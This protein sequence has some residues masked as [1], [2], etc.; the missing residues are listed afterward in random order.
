M[1]ALRVLLAIG[2]SLSWGCGGS[3]MTA[4]P[5]GP[6]GFDLDAT[7]P[8]LTFDSVRLRDFYEPSA[9]ASRLLLLRVGAAWCGT[10]RWHL[11]HTGELLASDIGPS[12]TIVD[13]V[14]ADE[15]NV[16]AT[17]AAV[18]A[19]RARIDAPTTVASDPA[20]QLQPAMFVAG[21]L[22]LIVAVDRRTMTIQAT[23]S[24]PD[25][26]RLDAEL[27]RAL[28]R[29]NKTALA[30]GPST[31]GPDGLHRNQWD[32]V[33]E[34]ALP[35]A[36]PPDPTNA[37]ADDPAAAA[38][39]RALYNDASLSPSGTVSCAT[40]HDPAKGF[41]DGR[42]QSV[43]VATGDRNAPSVLFASH[44]RWQ[45]WDGRAD[46]LWAQALGPFENPKEFDSSRLFVAHAI[47]DRYRAQYEAI[48]GALPPLSDGARF[49]ASGKPGSIEWMNMTAAD[50]QAVNRVYANVGK[51][52][53]AF[54][55]TLR[56]RPNA[57]DRY[58][59]GDA[60]ALTEEQKESLRAFFEGGCAQCHYGP[61]LT[62]DAF[63]AIR[64]PTGRPDGVGDPGR[65]EG[66]AKLRA[67]E[68]LGRGAYSDAPAA[69]RDFSALAPTANMRGAFK[70]PPLRGIAD[71]A[72][73]GHGGTIATL[74]DVA[75]LYGK[76]GLPPEDRAAVGA[77]EPW[78]P[79]FLD[80]DA[81]KLVPFLQLLTAEPEPAP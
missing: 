4:Y 81:A 6:Y 19:Y 66:I 78:L 57:L 33:R 69:A 15:D 8:D 47:F 50:Q 40:C 36:P 62:D 65:E 5:P 52:I 32:L 1:R 37:K 77:S 29:L 44:A 22:P 3:S 10:C 27:K 55:R 26:D 41:A 34:M 79:L 28:N 23:L 18:P 7:L 16:P 53:A 11:A 56:A 67:S 71:T 14:V 13:L 49:P 43:G 63:H 64:F 75:T 31:D 68:F 24:D 42:A 39:G 12:L 60:T 46:S 25:P 51:A 17:P 35:G 58:I 73:Y 20:F 48:F 9:P 80:G 76:A 45:F 54:E 59:A 2:A 74:L 61:R 72:P 30:P 21:A 38:L 70:T